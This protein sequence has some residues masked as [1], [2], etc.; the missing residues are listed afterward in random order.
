MGYEFGWTASNV[1]SFNSLLRR[2]AKEIPNCS[3]LDV[4]E[5]FVHRGYPIKSLFYDHLHPSARGAAVLARSFIAVTRGRNFSVKVWLE[6][7]LLDLHHP[8]HK[9]LTELFFPKK[10][11][12][13]RASNTLLLLYCVSLSRLLGQILSPKSLTGGNWT[14]S[15]V[16]SFWADEPWCPLSNWN[17]Q[18]PIIVKIFGCGCSA[19]WMRVMPDQTV[20]W[21]F[22]IQWLID[23]WFNF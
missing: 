3:Y 9:N 1:M 5:D 14:K 7:M 16:S 6:W 17:L 4:F 10:T 23:W 18:G 2:C 11:K 20:L 22:H 15:V 12:F 8:G 13:N 21:G 19:K